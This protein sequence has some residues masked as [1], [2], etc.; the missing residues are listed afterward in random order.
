M[1]RA[2]L[3]LIILSLIIIVYGLISLRKEKNEQIN[4]ENTNTVVE[5]DE[6]MKLEE[7]H[8]QDSNFYIV[9]TEDSSLAWQ[10]SQNVIKNE[11]TGTVGFSQGV[12][13]YSEGEFVAGE[14]VIDM[15]SITDD[16]DNEFLEK[17]LK[18]EDFFDVASHP[19]AKLKINEV[20]KTDIED[21]YRVKA[22]LTIKKIT[23]PVEFDAT[24]IFNN[25]YLE[26]EANFSIDRTKWDVK[27]GSGQFFEDVGDKII[28]DKIKFKANILAQI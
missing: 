23:H 1:K 10:G 19:T 15:Q 12:I 22:D 14:F 2:H 16:G 26:A 28:D 21:I 18:G 4:Q 7:K 9:N 24:V 20:T 13:I 6:S 11:H 8:P 5:Q 3:A 17:H 27:Y 25:E